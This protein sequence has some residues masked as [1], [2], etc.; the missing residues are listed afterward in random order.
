MLCC[1]GIVMAQTVPESIVSDGTVYRITLTNHVVTPVIY[2]NYADAKKVL[3]EWRHQ[4]I[5]WHYVHEYPITLETIN[6][7]DMADGMVQK[8][9]FEKSVRQSLSPRVPPPRTDLGQEKL[10]RQP[11][12]PP[13][14]G[15]FA[16]KE[17]ATF[18]PSH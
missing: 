16:A 3:D 12:L 15:P 8:D 11:P 13:L 6:T 5:P 7:N 2:T 9:P 18:T 1:C 14:P 10:K 17:R 4:N